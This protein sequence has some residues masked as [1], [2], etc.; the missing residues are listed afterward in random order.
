MINNI[1]ITLYRKRWFL[2]LLCGPFCNV[3]K[4]QITMLQPETNTILYI[5]N[6]S[7]KI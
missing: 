3:F 6:I 2:D 7:L 1:I 4:C 5:N